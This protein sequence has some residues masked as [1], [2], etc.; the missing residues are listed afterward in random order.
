VA[1]V[2]ISRITQR[3]GLE[4]DLPQ[5]LAG[6]ELGWAI[7]QR[8]LFI[9]NGNP[10]DGAPTVGNT[11]ILTEFSDVLA[12]ANAYTYQGA[13]AGYTVQTGATPGSPVSQNLQSWLDQFATVRD[14]GATGDGVTDD[15]AA[16]NRALHEL[17][18]RQVNPQIRRSLFFPAGVYVVSDTIL[19]PPYAKLYGEGSNSSIIRFTAQIWAANTAYA[20]GVLVKYDDGRVF[21]LYR[22]KQTVPA[23]GIAITD[24]TYWESVATLPAFVARTADSLQQ[25][26]INIG[27]NNAT[28]PRNVEI[29]ALA[30]ETTEYAND[31]SLG[32]NHNVFLIEQAQQ[33]SVSNSDFRGPLLQ[34]DL[35]TS[36]EDLSGIKFAST[37]ARICTNVTLDQCRLSGLTYGINT[38]DGTKG[39]TVSNSWFDTLYQ[40]IV[41]G[42]STPQNG[43]PTGFRIISNIFDNIYAQGVVME[44][45]SLNATSYNTFYDV[46]N[47]FFGYPVSQALSFP[48]ISIEAENNISV[49]DLFARTDQQAEI[50]PRI[51]IYDPNTATLVS[52]L[53][54]TNARTF[55][56]GCWTRETGVQ[57][58]LIAGASSVALFTIDTT[59]PISDNGF[60]AFNMQYTIYRLTDGTKAVRTGLLTV[61]AGGDD[62]AGEGIVWSDDYMENEDT[63][64]TL[65]VTESSDVVTVSYSSNPS[66]F[67]GTIFY[68]LTHLA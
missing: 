53:A 18:C 8:R 62:S 4:E 7:D 38:D 19:I 20:A 12:L 33:I 66:E 56:M 51:S 52:S 9:G 46:G 16:I 37:P 45:C 55:Q 54:T 11:E 5:P 17:Y 28:P 24:T 59:T 58:S 65:Q 67:D 57:Q 43:G 1:I 50:N 41:L 6:A 47:Q 2:Q 30:W 40:G 44:Q 21:D 39:I 49:G 35:S 25:T 32:N 23:D 34:S 10:A 60:Q 61:V 29:Q 14:F 22:S 42:D 68:S 63:G 64:V 48:V 15:T 31:S 3:K 13:A 36:L 27:V 26:G